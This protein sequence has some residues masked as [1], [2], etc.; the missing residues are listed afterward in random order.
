MEQAGCL[1]VAA[2]PSVWWTSTRSDCM[3]EGHT[4]S[5][6]SRQPVG[7]SGARL[8]PCVRHTCSLEWLTQCTHTLTACSTKLWHI[9]AVSENICNNEMHHCCRRKIKQKAV[10][11]LVEGGWLMTP[12]LGAADHEIKQSSPSKSRQMREE[13]PD[14]ALKRRHLPSCSK[15]QHY[16]LYAE[17]N[18]A[19][20]SA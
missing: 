3:W 19:C 4:G 14:R 16:L 6:Q 15:M 20:F 5:S 13:E 18:P 7:M 9:R 17:K 8:H 1:K 10:Q 12:V 2:S 11:C